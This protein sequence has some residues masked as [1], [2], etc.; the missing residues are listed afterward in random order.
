MANSESD[1]KSE[2]RQ[3]FK[4][5]LSVDCH[6]SP[7]SSE[8]DTGK[9]DIYVRVLT[10]G[11]FWFEAKF[12]R[13]KTATKAAAYA[14]FPPTQ[15]NWLK[16]E[17]RCGG[18]AVWL[19]C[20]RVSSHETRLYMGTEDTLIKDSAHLIQTKRRGDKWDVNCILLE[21]LKRNGECH[22]GK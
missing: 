17:R 8:Y 10:M 2:L 11:A 15:Q 18:I 22:G 1:F 4:D 5:A 12:G 21:A 14:K 16:A 7:S 6:W 9:A 13:S 20:W 3:A 19:Y